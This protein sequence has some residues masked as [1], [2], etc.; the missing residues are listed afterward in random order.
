LAVLPRL[1]AYTGIPYPFAKL[2][3]LAIPASDFSAVENPGLITYRFPEL[4][5]A[6]DGETPRKIRS[7]R[8][9]QAHEIAHQ[10]FG[11]LVTQADWRDVWLSE[12]IATWLEHKVMDEDQPVERARLDA[13]VSREWMMQTDAKPRARPVRV[14]VDS[15]SQA[16]TIYH[17]TVYSKGA[18]ILMMLE[19]WL[20]EDRFRDGLRAYLDTHR[21]S[22]ATTDDLARALRQAS[23]IDVAPVMH[24]FLDTSGVPEVRG[25]I[26]CDRTAGAVL[27]I[28]QTGSA[29]VPVCWRAEG[30]TG[31]CAV[32]DQPSRDVDLPACSTW[33][34]LNAGGAGYYRTAFTT[35]QVAAL[36][37]DELSAAERLTLVYDLRARKSDRAASRGVLT[38]LA[39]DSDPQ[40]A[41]V[42][43]DALK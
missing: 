25:E 38:K 1:E 10:W 30:S 37:L 4:L 31:S 18:S 24:A 13:I 43:R 26:R 3:H 35:A 20:G 27:H 7:I 5:V 16:A 32:L 6:P 8:A 36:P 34:Y 39:S 41:A 2:D 22:T 40:V 29:A 12:G 19:R 11:N 23:G 14:A 28:E 15:R 21:F 17:G 42:A 33:L 9:L